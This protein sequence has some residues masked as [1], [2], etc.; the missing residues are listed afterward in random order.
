VNGQLAQ[1]FRIVVNNKRHD[2]SFISIFAKSDDWKKLL[3]ECLRDVGKAQKETKFPHGVYPIFTFSFV[4]LF[5][6]FSFSF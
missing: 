6:F 5:F 1:D 2:N 4:S 3:L